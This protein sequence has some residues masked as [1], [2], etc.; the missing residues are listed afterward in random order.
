LTQRPT[1][2]VT[3][4]IGSIDT[5]RINGPIAPPQKTPSMDRALTLQ[6]VRIKE[7][8]SVI[9]QREDSGRR[10]KETYLQ[11]EAIRQGFTWNPVGQ[12]QVAPIPELQENIPSRHTKTRRPRP[13]QVEEEI[14]CSIL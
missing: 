11:Q 3:S 14:S 9:S 10:L 4:S 5:Y 13:M 8:L 12:S 2:E 7:A 1:F 6:N